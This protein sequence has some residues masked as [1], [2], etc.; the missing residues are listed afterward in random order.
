MVFSQSGGSL[1][2]QIDHLFAPN[3][4]MLVTRKIFLTYTLNAWQL[5]TTCKMQMNAAPV[6][7]LP[8]RILSLAQTRAVHVRRRAGR[9]F[10]LAMWSAGSETQWLVVRETAE[11]RKKVEPGNSPVLLHHVVWKIYN[12]VG[13][14][15]AVHRLPHFSEFCYCSIYCTDSSCTAAGLAL[16]GSHASDAL[17][18][19][20]DPRAVKVTDAQQVI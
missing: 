14:Y 20:S 5:R 17:D 16:A 6:R 1:S 8:P 7:L 12:R 4:P 9:H 3:T 13:G 10:I 2:V 11:Y 18:H 15:T 19:L